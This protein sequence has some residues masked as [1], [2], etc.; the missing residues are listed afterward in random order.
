VATYSVTV[1]AAVNNSACDDV[2]GQAR[3]GTCRAT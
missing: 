1:S 2:P 3:Y